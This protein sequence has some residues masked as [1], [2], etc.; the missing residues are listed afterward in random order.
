VASSADILAIGARSYRYSSGA[1]YLYGSTKTYA[2]G[3]AVAGTA[4]TEQQRL[5]EPG[6][7]QPG[8]FVAV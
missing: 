8:R 1:V 2:A 6:S 5:L 3:G 7:L 4:W